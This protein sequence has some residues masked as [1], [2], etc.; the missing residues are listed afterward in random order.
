MLSPPWTCIL[1]WQ[2]V[3]NCSHFSAQFSQDEWLPQFSCLSCENC[4]CQT[5]EHKNAKRVQGFL[6]QRKMWLSPRL[7]WVTLETDHICKRVIIDLG[8]TM[9]S[10]QDNGKTQTLQKTWV[11]DVQQHLPREDLLIVRYLFQCVCPYI[12]HM[13]NIISSV[14]V[15]SFLVLLPLEFLVWSHSGH[16]AIFW[17]WV[18]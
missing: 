11:F 7:K 13:N 9:C 12:L 15:T 8:I 6:N 16:Y 3:L 17:D 2:S 14:T 5:P 10:P 1:S 4:E 18:L